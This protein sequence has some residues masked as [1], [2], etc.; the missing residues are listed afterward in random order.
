MLGEVSVLGGQE[1]TNQLRP[2]LGET[3]AHQPGISTS[4]SGPNVARPVLRGLSGERLRIL[5]DGIGSLDVSASSSDHAVAINPLTADAIEVL[6]G[7]AALLYGSSAIGGIVNV[8]DSRIPRRVPDAPLHGQGITGYGSAAH[9]VLAN[10]EVDVPFGSHFVVHGDANYTHNDDL[11]TGGYILSSPLRAE[12]TASAHPEVQSLARLKGKLPNSDGRGFEAAGSVAYI[13]GGF[14]AGVSITRHTAKYGVPIRFSLYPAIEAEQ[15]HIDV[16]QTRYDARVEAPLHG[17]FRQIRLRGGYSD[18]NHKELGADGSI[19]SQVFSKG[20]EARADLVQ[21]DTGGWGG[22]SGVQY[23]DIR[24]H[25]AGDEQYLPPTGQRTLG[26]FSVQHIETGPLRLEAGARFERTSL[27]AQASSVVGN[28]DLQRRYSTLSVS[29]GGTYALTPAW[30]LGLNIAR[31]QRAPS[32]D[33]VFANGPHG[34]NASF[35]LGDPD[36]S[37]E[38]SIGF[39]AS[40]KHRSGR[41][42]INATYYVSRYSNFIYQAPTGEV[43]DDLPVYAFRQGRANYSGFEVEVDGRLG[44]VHGIDLGVEG[45]AD[46]SRVSI[47]DFGPAPLIPPLRLQGALTAKRGRVNGRVELEHDFAH[48]RTA[49]LELPTSGFTLVNAGV[50]WHPLT[51][52][53]DLTLSLAAN[54]IFDVEARRSAS[55][56]KDYAPLAGRDIRLTAR[57]SY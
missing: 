27:K 45:I 34:G 20:G 40:V 10:G 11:R 35:E 13:D 23:L 1:L 54:N 33:E 56:L 4:G 53:H 19:G 24:Q 31:S 57:F 49:P 43:R 7:P 16:H 32:V 51:T 2:T 21:R 22:D 39:E 9:E 26:L 5:T 37:P 42:D 41:L 18:Y 47:K 12:A 3:L 25:I 28:R 50:D 55:L 14:N 6:H 46:A 52:R 29:A 15:T 44:S 48:R 36:L 8:I 38:K 17:A 30:T